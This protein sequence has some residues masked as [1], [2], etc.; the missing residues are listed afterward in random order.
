MNNCPWTEKYRPENIDEVITNKY[1]LKQLQS[2]L[3]TKIMPNMIISGDS[4]IGKTS[5]ILCIAKNLLSSNYKDYVLEL[6]AADDRGIT[7]IQESITNFCKKSINQSHNF[8]KIVLL[9]EADSLSTKSQHLI[10]NLMDTYNNTTRFALTCNDS[11]SIIESVQSR[12]YILKYDK[13]TNEQIYKKLVQ[14]CKSEDIPIDKDGL[15]YI[16]Y[17]S[18]GDLR[19]AINY[20][21]TVYIGFG[22][23]SLDNVCKLCDKPGPII[24]KSIINK[25]GKQDFNGIIKIICKLRDNGYSSKDII[26]SIIELLKNYTHITDEIKITYIN[27]L[28]KTYVIICTSINS[29]L[30]LFACFAK[31]CAKVE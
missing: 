29:D 10:S 16:V 4:G 13:L 11:S 1:I 30:Q 25:C 7:I 31:L 24:I 3:E 15:E 27:E 9:D 20:L 6:N 17:S 12:C 22:N 23:V 19:S 2:I 26:L 21:Q 8:H 5:T 14:I 28:C 18:T